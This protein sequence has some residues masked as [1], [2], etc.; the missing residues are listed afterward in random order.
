MQNGPAECH[1][2]QGPLTIAARRPGA[3]LPGAGRAGYPRAVSAFALSQVLIGLAFLLDLASF[4]FRD[5]R[6][7]LVCLAGAATLIGAHFFLLG[8]HTAAVLG[9]VAAL[10]FLTAIRWRSKP[11]LVLFMAVVLVNAALT[12]SGLLTALA[13]GGSLLATVAPFLNS[14]RAFRK[15]MMLASVVWIAHNILAV[16]PAAIALESFFLLSNLV[17]YYRHHIRGRQR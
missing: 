9:L 8:I 3:A 5:R 11:L 14:D 13:T 17:G 7:V 1:S 15:T 16:T 6:Y 2:G 4:Q 12:W 10:R